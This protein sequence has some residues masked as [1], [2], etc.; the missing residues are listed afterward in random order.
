MSKVNRK[1]R[2]KLPPSSEADL[3]QALGP[4]VQ[5][6]RAALGM[7]QAEMSEILGRSNNNAIS[8]LER[9]ENELIALDLLAGLTR[10]ARDAGY[11]AEWLLT[12]ESNVGFKKGFAIALQ[13][14]EQIA[15]NP[16]A[17]RSMRDL[18]DIFEKHPE[19][20]PTRLDKHAAES[21]ERGEA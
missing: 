14:I 15:A 9:G 18:A 2:K 7:T 1:K 8:R 20:D 17:W 3:R 10:L 6:V 12:G 11:S 21:A 13:I 19:L 5:L 4:R 16:H